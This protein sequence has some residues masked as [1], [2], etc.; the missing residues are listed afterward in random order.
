MRVLGEVCYNL[1]KCVLVLFRNL[2]KKYFEGVPMLSCNF[3]IFVAML[4]LFAGTIAQV[5]GSAPRK[6]AKPVEDGFWL[7]PSKECPAEPIIGHKD[8]L[9]I[10]IHPIHNGPRGLIRIHVPYV[11]P[12]EHSI[13]NFIAIE[14]IVGGKRGFSELERSKLDNQQ[15]LRMWFSDSQDASEKLSWEAPQ[16][17]ISHIIVGGKRIETLSV[18]LHVEKFENGAHPYLKVIFRE[19]RPNEVGFQVYAHK[20]SAQ[21]ESCILTATMGNYTRCRLLWLK[22]EVVDS[23]DIWKDYQGSDFVYTDDFPEERIR[24]EKDGTLIVA[25]TPNETNLAVPVPAGGWYYGGKAA[26][27]Y[28]R[29]Y[30]SSSKT[31]GVRVRVNGRAMYYGT[32]TLIPGGVAFE[33]FELIEAFKPGNELWFGVTLRTPK[34]M[35]WEI[36]NR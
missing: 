20:D 25:I 30:P 19:D 11:N 17:E 16:G 28:W 21:M 12:G 33:N 1:T 31:T 3:V 36:K 34:E 24:R 2:D 18:Y 22:D 5:D 27:Q 32:N 29:K 4:M 15:G 8:G 14:P 26:T 23:R 6:L 10:S 13:V 7:R 9:R 35:G